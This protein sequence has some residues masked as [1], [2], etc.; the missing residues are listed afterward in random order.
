MSKIISV[1]S[2]RGGTGKSNT[3]A[4]LAAL[5][6]GMGK[7]V[8][9][10]DTDIISPGIHV[11]FQLQQS[12]IKYTL[13]DYLWGNCA[14]KDT[15]YDILARLD[16]QLANQKKARPGGSDHSLKSLQGGPVKK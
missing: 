5:M 2:F 7:R 12:E 8:G 4:N 11:L 1:H 6:A 15:A 13:N 9:V 3:C 16:P 14:I 10:I